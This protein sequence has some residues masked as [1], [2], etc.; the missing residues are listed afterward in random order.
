MHISTVSSFNFADIQH[1]IQANKLILYSNLAY[2]VYVTRDILIPKI[3]S[4][5]L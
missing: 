2:F 1:A 4:V 5:Q 3:G